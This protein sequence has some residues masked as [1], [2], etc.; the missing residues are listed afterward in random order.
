MNYVGGVSKARA[1]KKRRQRARA[2]GGM[3]AGGGGAKASRGEGVPAASTN[4]AAPAKASLGQRAAAMAASA[5]K[6]S[7]GGE[8]PRP[9]PIWA[10]FPL[11]EIGIAAGIII[12]GSGLESNNATTLSIGALVLAVVVG[13]LCLR[14]HFAG[15]RSH[16]LLLAALTVAVAHGVVV[17]AITD[18]WRGPLTLA[19]DLAAGG[20]LVWWLRSRFHDA[21]EQHRAA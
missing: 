21:R 3:P 7:R 1:K 14:E 19:A 12:F 17:F 15:F 5:G 10:P 8:V 20:A 13:E 9:K 6:A 4:A 11:T 18:A 2:A 16:T